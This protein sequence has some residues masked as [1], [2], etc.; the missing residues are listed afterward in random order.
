[1]TILGI[2]HTHDISWDM[3]LDP[4]H[5]CDYEHDLMVF[6]DEPLPVSPPS[7]PPVDWASILGV[8]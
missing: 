8:E 3:D 7:G 4:P 2:C 5:E 1:M 6:E